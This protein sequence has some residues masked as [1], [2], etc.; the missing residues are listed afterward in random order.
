VVEVEV[1]TKAALICSLEVDVSGLV[2]SLLDLMVRKR[3]NQLA[4]ILA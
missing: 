3:S 2:N 1:A 4:G